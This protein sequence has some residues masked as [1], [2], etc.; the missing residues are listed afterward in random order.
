MLVVASAGEHEDAQNDD[1]A[2]NVPKTDRLSITDVERAEAK[3]GKMTA[4]AKNEQYIIVRKMRG[5]Q[6]L[7][8][9]RTIL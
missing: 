9:N 7:Q 6:F 3:A 8:C 1:V 4:T 5:D 2:A